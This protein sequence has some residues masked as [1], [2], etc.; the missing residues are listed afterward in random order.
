MFKLIVLFSFLIVSMLPTEAKSECD[1]SGIWN[2]SSKPAKLVVD[3]TKDEISVHSHDNNSK[4]I[5]LVVLKSLERAKASSSWTA[6]MY[7]AAEDSFVAVQM[8]AKGCNQL[9]VTFKGEEV[10]RLLR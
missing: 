9:M 5:G 3:L 6:K 1:I 4:A 10:L 8:K 2:H 7:S